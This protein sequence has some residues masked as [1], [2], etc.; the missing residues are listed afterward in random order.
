[1]TRFLS[2]LAVAA[3]CMAGDDIPHPNHNRSFVVGGL[4]ATLDFH[5]GL[6]GQTHQVETLD[7][8][9]IDTEGGQ[10]TL[11]VSPS[12]ESALVDSGNP[13][14]RDVGRIM[15]VVRDV[16]LTQIDYLVTTHYHRDHIGGMQE[17]AAQISIQHF[18]DHGPSVEARE[19]FPGFDD[20]YATL[21]AQ[22]EYTIALPGDQIPIAGL[23]WLIITAAGRTLATPLPGAGQPNPSCT[24][25]EPREISTSLENASSTGS[26]ITYGRF[27]MIDLGDLLWNN[28][29]ELMCPNNSIG[30]VDLYLTTH[31]GLAQSGSKVVVHGLE[32]RVAIMN[33]GTRKGGS[34]QALQ[35]LH[36]SPGLEDLW[37]LH[38][39]YHGGTE[40]NAP[41]AFIANV[42]DSATRARVLTEATPGTERGDPAHAPAYLIKVSARADGSF[43][44]TNTRN[45]FAKTYAAR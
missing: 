34:V 40:H 12:G 41:G 39:S 9:F 3:L 29:F 36:A 17:L 7:I 35:I 43:T 42:G 21:R 20:A 28:E 23:D 24:S 15:A 27:R 10:A 33:N 1:M 2:V 30:A 32:P 22:A 16:G 38:W 11:F 45:G 8:Y 37:Q 19:P 44:V 6:P 13:G 26:L 5:H 31:H 4:G 18:V 14:G 25:F